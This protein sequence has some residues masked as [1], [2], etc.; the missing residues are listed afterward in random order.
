MRYPANVPARNQVANF[1]SV[2]APVGGW[3]ALDA[4][5][6]MKP[7]EAIT[8]DNWY[9]KPTYVEIRGGSASHAT[10]MTG[11]GKTLVVYRALTGTDKMFCSTES[12]VYNVSVSGAVGASVASRTN[13]KHQWLMF[14]DGT[15]NWLIMVNGV[16]KPLYY[17]GTTWIAVD[18]ASSPA[19]TGIT[20]TKL[21]GV[22]IF[23]GRLIFL[24]KD[25]LSFWYLT[26]GVAGGALTRFDLSGVAQKGGY[27]MAASSWTVDSGAGPDDRMVFVTS[28]GEVIVYQGTNPGS[29]STWALIGVYVIG[30]PLGRKCIVKTGSDLVIITQNGA[31]P[32]SAIWQESG[33]NYARAVSRKIEPVFNDSARLYGSNFGWKAT[34]FQAQSAIIFNVPVLENGTHYQYVMNTITQAWCRFTGWNAEDFEVFNGELYYCQGTTVI[35]AWTGTGDQGNNIDAYAKGAFNYF[36]SRGQ[37]KKF[38]LYR[39][40]FNVNSSLAFLTD[41]DIDFDNKPIV[42]TASYTPTNYAVFGVSKWGDATWAPG[43]IAV[44]NWQVSS[45]WL[46]YCAATK[47]KISTKTILVQWVSTDYIIEVG[48]GL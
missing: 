8:L 19:L 2:Q 11:T 21:V 18:G 12:G 45:N 39:P 46:G 20:T 10:G 4:L 31:F 37:L 27:I 38:N 17:D 13:G 34:L 24:E 1:T 15:S 6:D 26:S 35:K 25:S 43:L 28:A 16:D 47:I 3:N 23:K 42:A 29:A 33:V 32:L 44:R 40:V 7:S 41:L 22:A 9:P 36:S 48:S 14:G 30:T 5:A